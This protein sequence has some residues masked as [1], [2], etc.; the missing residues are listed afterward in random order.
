VLEQQDA[1]SHGGGHGWVLE[2]QD[3]ES[4]GGGGHDGD[5][6]L[7]GVVHDGAGAG[8]GSA[9]GGGHDGSGPPAGWG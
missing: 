5:D 1:V 4:H 9:H 3:A 7:T 2:Q 6:W 8:W